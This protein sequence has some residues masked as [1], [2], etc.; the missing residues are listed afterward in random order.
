MRSSGRPRGPALTVA[1]IAAAVLGPLLVATPASAAVATPLP[2]AT[3]FFVPPADAGATQ[4]IAQLT[5]AGNT[6]SATLLRKEVAVPRAAWFTGGTPS[7]VRTAVRN[8]VLQASSRAAVPV[9][10]M[11]DVPGRDCGQYSAG[12]ALTDAAYRAWATGFAQG[13]IAGQRVVVVVE[14]DALAQLPS[15]CPWA[16]PGQNVAALSAT[17]IAEVKAAGE[18]VLRADPSALVYLDAGTSSWLAVG[19]AASRLAQAGVA[20]FQG[21]ALNVANEQWTPNLERYGMWISACLAYATKV[22]PGGFG[23]CADQYWNGGPANGWT[24]VALDPDLVWSDAAANPRA[25]TAGVTSRYT[26]MLGSV[27]PTTHF[28]VDTSRNGLG[29]W[30]PK[31]TPVTTDDAYPDPQTWCDAPGRGLG[32]RP[33]GAPAAAF[34]L[35]D[36]FLWVKTPGESDGPCTRGIAGG[37]LDP[38]WGVADPPAGAWFPLEA[39]QLARLATPPLK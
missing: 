28:V 9:L 5:Q 34:P 15:D 29:P 12:G 21:F 33:Q 18:A 2:P 37:I 11:Y 10:V 22:A 7:Q 3:S 20:E 26:A 23:S 19:P 24:G 14:P 31:T 27:R 38:E 6:T 13:L 17:R 16:Y 32:A 4:Q 35:L 30:D 8:T 36:A 39:L 25:N 1:A